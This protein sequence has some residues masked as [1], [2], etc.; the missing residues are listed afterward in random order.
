M[1]LTRWNPLQEL[2]DISDRLNRFFARKQPPDTRGNEPLGVPDWVPSVDILETADEFIIKAE[3][4]AVKKQDV[5]VLV[6]EGVLTIQGEQ[7]EPLALELKDYTAHRLECASGR[8][9]RSFVLPDSIEQ[10]KVTAM[11]E[12]GMLYLRLPKSAHTK[13]KLVDVKVA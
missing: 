6:D 5:R 8:F 10:A 4:P 13:P 7:Q 11:V 2:K 9:M 12:N 3:L 1:N